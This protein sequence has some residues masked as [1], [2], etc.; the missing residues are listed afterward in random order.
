MKEI[1]VRNTFIVQLRSV[2][3]VCNRVLLF[4]VVSKTC[5]V[6]VQDAASLTYTAGVTFTCCCC[7]CTGSPILTADG[8]QAGV[9]SFALGCA[10]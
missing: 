6:C 1:Q 10:R 8:V 9:V 7:C 5:C 2:R 3:F 4:F